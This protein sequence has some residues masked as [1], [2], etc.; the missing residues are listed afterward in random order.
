MTSPPRAESWLILPLAPHG[1]V[2]GAYSLQTEVRAGVAGRARSQAEARPG[3]R[4]GRFGGKSGA[5]RTMNVRRQS[6]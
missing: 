5:G 6:Q 3:M 4:R 1:S 2:R